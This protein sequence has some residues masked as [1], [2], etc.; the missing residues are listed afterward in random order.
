MFDTMNDSTMTSDSCGAPFAQFDNS[1]ARLPD[2]FFARQ[3]PEP[4]SAPGLL[5]LNEPLARSL[6]MNVALLRSDAG[7]AMLAGNTVPDGAQPIAM[8]YAGH[9]FGG[10]V[11]QLGDGRAILLGEVIDEHGTRR[12]IQ[13]KGAGRTPFS[14]GGDGRA[15]L[16]PV[17][18]EYLVSEAMQALGIPSTRALAALTT[19]D[20]VMRERPLPGALVVRVAVGHVRVGTFQFFAARRNLDALR[21]L[22]DYVI[23]RH[24][25]AVADA[26]RPALAL[27]EAVSRRQAELVARWQLVG[28][29]HGVM[30]TDNASIVGETIDF[31]PCA[32]LDDYASDKVFSAI[33]VHG[34][35]AY[36]N[37][38][39]IA[40][41]NMANLAQCLLPLIDD[42]TDKAAAAAQAVIDDY[43]SHYRAAYAS[44]LATKLG[45]T[46]T[47]DPDAE[48]LA[49]G[50][51]LLERM[52]HHSADFTRTFTA[53]TRLAAAADSAREAH[54]QHFVEAFGLSRDN[55]DAAPLNDWLCDWQARRDRLVDPVTAT[56]AMQQAN[57]VYIPR[58]HRIEA[59][60]AAALEDDL[61]VFEQLMEVL[62]SPFETRAQF[63]EYERAPSEGEQV[64]Q[65]FC[66]T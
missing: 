56:A 46:S 1:Y 9:Q 44:G 38:P 64:T 43:P 40:Q 29:V 61:S 63:G 18:R 26:E 23:A 32:F 66:G 28:F 58:N 7:I 45:L 5:A 37:Q 48:T 41:W 12:D 52:Q 11:P 35:Y 13:L 24:Y 25:P 6:G 49:L 33:D 10:W 3:A 54:R 30:N 22:T 8:A 20:T 14:R 65:T 50:G 19:G 57:P 51:A 21:T 55:D 62:A 2:G 17:L 36:G 16:G 42:D 47:G 31:G 60:I 4:V 15:W 27:L 39:Q 34:R 53:L 59:A